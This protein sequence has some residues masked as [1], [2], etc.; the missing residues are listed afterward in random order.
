M[1]TSPQVVLITGANTGI[2]EAVARS[3]ATNHGYHVIIGSRNLDAG[4]SVA[5]SLT[6][7]GLHASTVHL[8]LDDEAS[9][10]AAA[11]TIEAKHGH[12]DVL[13]NNAAV[14]LEV[15]SRNAG[16]TV[17]QRFEQT[18]VPN[19][20]G[21]VGVTEAML[22]LLRKANEPRI[23]FVSSRLGSLANALDPNAPYYENDFRSYNCSKAAL[24]VLALNYARMLDDVGGLVNVVCPGLVNTRLSG[25]NKAGHT[26]EVGAERIVEMATIG[27]GG[28]TRTFS[29]KNG[30]IEW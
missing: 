16:L 9:I 26:P 11:Q 14:F 20:F 24:N 27:K 8:D 2:G 12:L 18:F 21:Q 6:S 22:P 15:D 1:S 28:P 10:Q 17:R 30:P 29:D 5:S 25:Y 3:L 19:L 4:K 13:I 7:R 23:V